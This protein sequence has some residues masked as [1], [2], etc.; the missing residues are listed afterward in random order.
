MKKFIISSIFLLFTFSYLFSQDIKGTWSG[1]LK[2]GEQELKI[3]FNVDKDKDGNYSC[4]MDVPDQGGFGIPT[5]ISV[6]AGDSVFIEVKPLNILYSGKLFGK[7]IIKG[8]FN[9]FGMT[10]PLDLK[11]GNDVPKPKRPQEPQKPLSY[12]T[13]D[14][15]FFNDKEKIS[16]DGTLTYPLNYDKNKKYPVVIMISGS[17]QQNRDEEVYDHKPFLVISDYLAKNGIASLRYDDR[18]TG[19]SQGD[20]SNCTTEDFKNDAEYGV[21]WLK[22]RGLF[23]KIGALGHSEGGTI[24]FILGAKKSIDFIVSMAGTAIK[25]DSI[26]AEQQNEYMKLSGISTHKTAK[27]VRD[28]M[29]YTVEN[30]WLKYFMDLDPQKYISEIKIPVM[31]INGSNDLQVISSS[32]LSVIKK[33]L[34][35]KNPQNIIKEYKGLNHLFQHCEY[36]DALNYFSIEETC[37]EEVMSDIAKWIKSLH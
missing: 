6:K 7:D 29:K 10:I 16:L 13:E 17:G 31:A 15:T 12:K 20:P 11:L 22:K 8:I 26:L 4:K 27:Q 34:H 23:N 30:K 36:K 14:V 19:K 3:F 24:A 37:S 18:G 28:E 35:G 33:L 1:A 25:G 9:Q 2:V 5:D 21:I 32:N